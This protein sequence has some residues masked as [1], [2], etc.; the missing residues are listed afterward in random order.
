[1]HINIQY[2]ALSYEVRVRLWKSQLAGKKNSLTDHQIQTLSEEQLDGRAIANAVHVG[3]LMAKE[4]EINF[5]HLQRG[6]NLG[7]PPAEDGVGVG[8][9]ATPERLSDL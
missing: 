1:M 5:D 6:I 9:D 8:I 2:L 3:S 7:R 4:K